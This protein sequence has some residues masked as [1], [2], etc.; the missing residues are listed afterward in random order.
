M[1]TRPQTPLAL[2]NIWRETFS[3]ADKSLGLPSDLS[4]LTASMQ[5]RQQFPY[6]RCDDWWYGQPG[7]LISTDTGEIVNSGTN[8][9]VTYLLAP[10]EY[11][12]R[13]DYTK[14][15]ITAPFV[16]GLLMI[17]HGSSQLTVLPMGVV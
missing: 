6:N 5:I 11:W 16:T 14:S 13:G 9:V 4:G 12:I 3:P 10:G 17:N 15:G 2:D 8:L 7:G 1:I